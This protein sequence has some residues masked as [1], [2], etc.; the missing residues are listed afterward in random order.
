[1]TVYTHVPSTINCCISDLL[2]HPCRMASTN[3]T[4]VSKN[5][6]VSKVSDAIL[7]LGKGKQS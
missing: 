1:M 2:P 5:S 4:S 6:S 7:G 3:F